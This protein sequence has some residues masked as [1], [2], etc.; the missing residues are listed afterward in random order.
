VTLPCIYLAFSFYVHSIMA[1]SP[2][3][4]PLPSFRSV[5]DEN[6]VGCG[7]MLQKFIAMTSFLL[8]ESSRLHVCSVTSQF[9]FYPLAYLSA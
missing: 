7:Q 5:V 6:Y 1:A 4:A 3:G 9:I 2:L 8:H